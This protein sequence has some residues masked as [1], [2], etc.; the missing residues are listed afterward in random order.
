MTTQGPL[1]T[2]VNRYRYG[3]INPVD[4]KPIDTAVVILKGDLVFRDA[5]DSDKYK[6]SQSI[7]GIAGA[8][9][10]TL[11]AAQELFHDT[12]LGPASHRSRVGDVL[13]IVCGTSG[14]YEYECASATFNMGDLVGI[15]VD[16]VTP[17]NIDRQRVI[18]VATPNL[19]IGRV[20][21]DYTANTT[22]VL[23]EIMSTLYNGGAQAAA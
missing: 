16:P 8:G 4:T 21:K 14:V 7:V 22:T 12:F 3:D 18:G 6:S 17:A 13:P 9:P 15:A 19:A 11:A 10:A 5:A 20:V 2:D 1:H 23:V